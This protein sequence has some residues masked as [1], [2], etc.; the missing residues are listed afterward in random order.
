LACLYDANVW[1]ALAFASHPQHGIASEHF[2]VRDCTPVLQRTYGSSHRDLEKRIIASL[3]E[4]QI[5]FSEKARRHN[6][7]DRVS[8]Y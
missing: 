2:Q 1:V 6:F 7:V 8:P 4:Y 5:E 3:N